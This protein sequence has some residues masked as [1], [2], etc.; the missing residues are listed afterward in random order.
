MRFK[1]AVRGSA[2]TG[3]G[4]ASL[5]RGG[6]GKPQRPRGGHR[7]YVA[8]EGVHNTVLPSRGY[9]P[10]T[11]L[12]TARVWHTLPETRV[13][14]MP[15]IGN[16]IFVCGWWYDQ[17]FVCLQHLG[18]RPPMFPYSVDGCCSQD[19]V[20]VRTSDKCLHREGACDTCNTRRISDGQLG[21]GAGL[22]VEIGTIPSGDDTP[23]RGRGQGAASDNRLYGFPIVSEKFFTLGSVS[24][25]YRGSLYLVR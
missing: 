21:H 5:P 7:R 20:S 2:S 16:N 9:R 22:C 6:D 14:N 1:V 8:R 13:K 25:P 10:G 17:T 3:E 18:W 11:S 19:R 24:T 4:K 12:K 23:G 15:F